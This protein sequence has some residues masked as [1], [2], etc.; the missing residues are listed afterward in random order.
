[1]APFIT[2]FRIARHSKTAALTSKSLILVMLLTLTSGC[3]VF[4]Y[5]FYPPA[6]CACSPENM[7]VAQQIAAHQE[8]EEEDESDVVYAGEGPLLSDDQEQPDADYHDPE[9]ASEEHA[10]NEEDEGDENE[11]VADIATSE[12]KGLGLEENTEGTVAARIRPPGS[13]TPAELHEQAVRLERAHQVADIVE[14][15]ARVDISSSKQRSEAEQKYTVSLATDPNIHVMT[16][17]FFPEQDNLVIITPGNS[18][19]IY[20]GGRLAAQRPLPKQ[21]STANLSE[22]T[23]DIAL[24]VRLVQND[25]LQILIYSAEPQTGGAILYKA[26]VYKVF[27]N[28]IGVI[29]D[30]T[31][32]KREAKDQPIQRIGQLEFLHGMNHR[33][34]RLTAVD[35]KGTPATEPRIFRWNRWEGAYRVPTP[36]PTAPKNQS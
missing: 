1:M 29:F 18:I 6:E 15:T 9:H 13:E 14:A 16:G 35:K 19:K 4:H 10:H 30:Q 34:I 7:L 17:E 24:P 27:G 26:R 22:L 28:E 23:A 2:L 36:P 3:G 5:V 33:F 11:E 8:H 32:A 21:D 25:S 12:L 20:A 31:I